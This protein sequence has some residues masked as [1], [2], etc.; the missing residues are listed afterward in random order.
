MANNKSQLQYLETFGF[1]S[2]LDS[3]DWPISL[4]TS[5]SDASNFNQ[6]TMK[7][8]ITTVCA[9]FFRGRHNNYANMTSFP[10]SPVI[11]N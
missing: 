4:P 3:Q 8:G 2:K 1:Q 9:E 6:I 11:W 7:F 5:G 10:D